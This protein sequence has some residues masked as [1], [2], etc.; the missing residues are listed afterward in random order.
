M[1]IKTG[2]RIAVSISNNGG[3]QWIS[4]PQINELN[5]EP[6]RWRY[7]EFFPLDAG[8]YPIRLA[9]HAELGSITLEVFWDYSSAAHQA[10]DGWAEAPI[11]DESK[12]IKIQFDETNSA[13]YIV[14]GAQITG[15]RIGHREALTRQYT[16]A[17]KPIS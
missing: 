15:P 4:V 13:Q 9:V 2:K 3:T 5:L 14:V 16:L 8:D 6:P 17:I 11:T 10:L 7:E 1:A 12:R